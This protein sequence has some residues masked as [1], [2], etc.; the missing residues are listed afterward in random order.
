MMMIVISDNH[1]R[2]TTTTFLPANVVAATISDIN[3]RM[4]EDVDEGDEEDEDDSPAKNGHRH[5]RR[6]NF[7]AFLTN[8]LLMTVDYRLQQKRALFRTPKFPVPR[9]AKRGKDD[10]TPDCGMTTS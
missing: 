10:V 7:L 6:H 8:N 2:T 1:S 4:V 5:S 3:L 9:F